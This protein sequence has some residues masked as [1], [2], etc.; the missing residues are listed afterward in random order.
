MKTVSKCCESHVKLR[1]VRENYYVYICE[2]CGRPCNCKTIK[3]KKAVLKNYSR[4]PPEYLT[5]WNKSSLII[6]ESYESPKLEEIK[7]KSGERFET[8]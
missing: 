4:F 8:S 6:T 1:E 2:G 5:R 7:F 3:E